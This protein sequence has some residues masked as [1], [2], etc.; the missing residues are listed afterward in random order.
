MVYFFK[1]N[2]S[3]ILILSMFF[4]SF[5]YAA[6]ST[7]PISTRYFNL[8]KKATT[9]T[10]GIGAALIAHILTELPIVVTHEYGH[11]FGNKISGGKGGKISVECNLYK[12]PLA[13]A[14]PFFANW[15]NAQKDGNYLVIMASGPLAGIGANYAI[16]AGTNSIYASKN[17]GSEKEIVKAGLTAPLRAYKDISDEIARMIVEQGDYEMRSF[18]EIFIMTFNLL[19]SSKM[20]GEFLYGLTPIS[21]DGGDGQQI[22]KELGLKRDCSVRPFIGLI[23]ACV[24]ALVAV[25]YGMAKGV[26]LRLKN[27]KNKQEN[28]VTEVSSEIVQSTI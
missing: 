13:V 20:F 19:K 26:Y 28:S 7:N 6:E 1:R 18:S 8:L 15:G 9:L 21:I 2:I 12:H 3:F 27:M 10:S 22:W 14:M 17:G 4:Q 11:H 24:P 16:M 23:L 25:S 5:S